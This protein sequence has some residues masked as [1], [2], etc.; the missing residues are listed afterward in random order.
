MRSSSEFCH[1]CQK[2]HRFQRNPE[3][4]LNILEN[5]YL[6][7]KDIESLNRLNNLRLLR[8][9]SPIDGEL[10]S[11][12]FKHYL[13]NLLIRSQISTLFYP[14][15]DTKIKV[16]CGVTSKNLE[17]LRQVA[18]DV[19]EAGYFGLIRVLNPSLIHSE[20]ELYLVPESVLEPSGDLPIPPEFYLEQDAV[21]FQQGNLILLADRPQRHL[22]SRDTRVS[23]RIALFREELEDSIT[24]IS[25][26]HAFPNEEQVEGQW[27]Y[28][29]L[30]NGH[31]SS[32]II[33]AYIEYLVRL[34][35]L[36][37][38]PYEIIQKDLDTLIG[39]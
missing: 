39:S 11:E 31:K 32:H 1:R 9:L 21:N 3:D 6:L 23:R 34:L 4:D 15:P 29:K 18:R 12:N 7:N 38:A 27:R 8:G 14:L 5:N 19:S 26:L 24:Y 2:W 17:A 25:F 37:D 16:Y 36:P 35:R 10:D 20:P 22:T 30:F 13:E 28:P 33:D